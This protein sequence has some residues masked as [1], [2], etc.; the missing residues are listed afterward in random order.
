MNDSNVDVEK[1]HENKD[2]VISSGRSVFHSIW[3]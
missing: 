1:E 3:K 2:V